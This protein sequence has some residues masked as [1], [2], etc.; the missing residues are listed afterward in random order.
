MSLLLSLAKCVKIVAP[1][2]LNVTTMAKIFQNETDNDDMRE[3]LPAAQVETIIGPSVRVEGNFFGEG[4]VVVEGEV[5][6]SLKTTKNLRVG[7][8]AVIEADVEAQT[9]LISGEVR[10]NLTVKDRTELTSTA[11]IHG[12]IKTTV[13]S[14]DSGAVVYGKCECGESSPPKFDEEAKE[15]KNKKDKE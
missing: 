9:A 3:E 11:R 4:D 1:S 14:I 13:I 7:E 15:K 8:R 12:D 10:G 5:V 6:G 2:I